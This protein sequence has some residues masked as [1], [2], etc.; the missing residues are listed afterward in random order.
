[1]SKLILLI[2]FFPLLGLF[3]NLFLIGKGKKD[4]L[5]GWIASAAMLSS[6]LVSF[7]IFFSFLLES[8]E[9]R[10]FSIFLF[11]W[12]PIGNLII[13]VGFVI[14][15][16]SSIMTLIITGVGFM[17]HVYSI[18]YMREDMGVVR[19]FIYLNLFSF[20]MLLLVLADNFLLM[21]VGWEAVGLCSY[22]LIGFWYEKPSATEAGKK[23]F[24][25]NRVGDFCFL[26]A[27][28]QILTIFGTFDF[29]DI[30]K[31]ASELFVKD[32]L[33]V[34]LLC[35]FLF[36]G[37]AGKSAQVP[38]HVWLP[39]AM[40][41]PTPVSALIHA[42]TMVTAGIYLLVRNDVLFSLAPSTLMIIA[43]IGTF[44]LLFA[45]SIALV[46]NDI[47]KVLA[48]STLSQLGYMFLACGLGAYA[49]AMFHLMTHAFFKALLFLGA[50]SVIHAMDGE[51]DIEKMGG[52][53]SYIPKTSFVFLI[54][55]LA[56]AGIF[57]LAGF[58]SKDAI[59]FSAFTSHSLSNLFWF[60]GILGA[61]M[62][63][64]YT[65]RVVFKVFY[66]DKNFDENKIHVHESPPIM[67]FPLFILAFFS[68]V[69]G[70][71]GIPIIS[72]GNVFA[73]FLS[74]AL[75]SGTSVGTHHNLTL[76]LVLMLLS[77][78]V[79]VLGIFIAY[80]TCCKKRQIFSRVSIFNIRI[81]S[82]LKNKYY[83]DEIY[84]FVL[85]RPLR[86]IASLFF[87][88]FEQNIID[89]TVNGTGR[90]VKSLGL[91][92]RSL[93]DGYVK[94]YAVSILFG[95]VCIILLLVFNFSNRF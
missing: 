51:Q 23:A 54:G 75:S 8:P 36:L 21:F 2:L 34:N 49:T 42:A 31:S 86:S 39:D 66:G 33:N 35:L 44:T 92:L 10:L 50:G 12:I 14:D 1:M 64:Y 38:L 17:V 20:S 69:G 24:I 93:Q 95:A 58:F 7:F 40:E 26:I 18:G 76:E 32:S 3:V 68:I 27:L 19:Y 13:K 9:D 84:D 73:E 60:A 78:V 70:W 46:Q 37:A 63:S 80:Q 5:S 47:K 67:I 90:L 11:D 91:T 74:S 29:T 85:V 28:F 15:P 25:V 52:I 43:I 88:L 6:F 94:T 30:S 61:L 22:L 81:H 65:F 48:Y 77:L 53:K 56:I 4:L 72:G 55:S 16:I 79:A 45:A 89:A 59:L 82:L 87:K 71:V 41:G 83:V 62:T 57:P